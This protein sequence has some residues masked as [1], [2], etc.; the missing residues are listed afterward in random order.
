[1]DA[2]FNQPAL[3]Q[4]ELGGPPAQ[5]SDFPK[6]RARIGLTLLLA[7]FIILLVGAKP[8]NFGLNRGTAIGF[9]QI[10]IM[11]FGLGLLTLGGCL[12]L[13]AFWGKKERSILADFGTRTCATGY[14]ICFFTALADAFGFGTNPLPNVFLGELQTNGLMIGMIIIAIGLLMLVHYKRE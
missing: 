14:V 9:L 11:L 1:M 8:E 7:G 5:K 13:L 6:L 3:D 10:I 12:A 4:T 2:S